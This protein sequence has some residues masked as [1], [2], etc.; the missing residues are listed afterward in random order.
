M[1]ASLSSRLRLLLDSAPLS[2]IDPRILAEREDSISAWQ[3]DVGQELASENIPLAHVVLVV[4]G[5]LR[6][7]GR[8][9][10]GNPFTLR[11]VHPGEWWGLWSALSGV[12]VATCRTTEPTKLLAVPVELWQSWFLNSVDLVNW[13]ESHPQREDL[14]SALRPLL[15]DCPRQ[16]RTFL[17]EID[18]LQSSLR[19]LQLRDQE[20][21]DGFQSADSEISWF[22]PS[23]TYLLPNVEPFGLEGLSRSTIQTAFEQ[24]QFGIRLVG[25][26][27]AELKHLSE[28]SVS[29]DA[30]FD[31]VDEGAGDGVLEESPEWKN[32]DGEQLLASP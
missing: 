2:N 17:D 6:V 28:P 18:Q 3:L 7:S 30:R 13:L 23:I 26:P 16:D 29:D 20:D 1:T 25:Y 21:I 22:S 24:S 8:D 5:S 19:T 27:T 12:S 9:A 31:Q 4:E 10:L 15:A 32:P 14:Y 11:R